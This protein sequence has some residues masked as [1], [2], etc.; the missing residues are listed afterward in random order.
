MFVAAIGSFSSCK[1]YDDDINSVADRVTALESSLKTCQSNCEAQRAALKTE[2]ENKIAALDSKYATLEAVAK[3]QSTA[4]NAKAEAENALAQ[5]VTLSGQISEIEADIE[6]IDKALEEINTVLAGKVDQ[7]DFDAAIESINAKLAAVNT[8]LATLEDGINKNSTAIEAV[9][10]DIAQQKSTLEN[11]GERISTLEEKIKDV[12]V[13]DLKE[14]FTKQIDEVKASI[15]KMQQALEEADAALEKKINANTA[16]IE[17]LK[18]GQQT[19]ANKI[20][21]LCTVTAQIEDDVESL[22]QQV[23]VLNVYVKST[24]RSLVFDPDLYYWGVEGTSL[25]V[26]TYRNYTLTPALNKD[27]WNFKEGYLG[28]GKSANTTKDGGKWGYVD[29]DKESD[30]TGTTGAERD[31]THN[32]FPYTEKTKTMNLVAKYHLN[33]SNA[34]IDEALANWET[35][36]ALNTEDDPFLK[37]TAN[38]APCSLRIASQPYYETVDGV[39]T[40]RLMVPLKV[41]NPDKIKSVANDQAITVFATEI[42]IQ[43]T[44][45]TDADTT[46]TSDYATLVRSDVKDVRIAHTLH[47]A[48]I[49]GTEIYS[50]NPNN[51][52]HNTHCGDCAVNTSEQNKNHNHVMATVHEAHNF[53]ET[54]ING[55]VTF[56]AQDQCL[57]NSRINL[58]DLVETH[59]TDVDGNHIVAGSD[60]MTANGL[61]YVFELTGLWRGDNETSESAHA[62]I[63][64]NEDGTYTFQPQRPDYPTTNV[65]EGRDYCDTDSFTTKNGQKVANQS[66]QQI[67]RTP[68]VRV[69]LVN[70][71]GEVL[72][73]GYIMIQ[74]TSEEE[75]TPAPELTVVEYTGD[76][77]TWTNNGACLPKYDAYGFKTQW[78]QTEY[79]IYSL[80]N[81]N[82]SRERF[83]DVYGNDLYG[84]SPATQF[85]LG[86][87]GNMYECDTEHPAIGKVMHHDDEDAAD[88]QM[89]SILEWSVE[90]DDIKDLI[91]TKGK[92]TDNGDGT[93]TYTYDGVDTWVMYEAKEAGY[94]DIFIHLNTGKLTYK[95]VTPYIADLN[96]DK[97]KIKEYWRE[98]DSAANGSDGG[99][100]ETHVQVLSPDDNLA[101]VCTDFDG[102]FSNLFVNNDLSASTWISSVENG[103]GIKTGELH[104]DL[105]FD[106]K[107][108]NTD[109]RSAGGNT[110]AQFKGI[111]DGKEVTFTMSVS[112]DGKTLFASYNGKKDTVAVIDAYVK[113]EMEANQQKIY[114]HHGEFAEALLNYKAHNEL[115]EDVL[116]AYIIANVY[117]YCY[118]ATG[119]VISTQQIEVKNQKPLVVRFLRPISV[120]SADAKVQDAALTKQI[121]KLA[122]LLQYIDWRDAWNSKSYNPASTATWGLDDGSGKYYK[123]YNITKIEPLDL[124]DGESLSISDATLT[125]LNQATTDT[126]VPLNTVSSE[127]DFIYHA[128]DNTIEYNNLSNTVQSFD[129]KFPVAVYYEWGDHTPIYAWVTIHVE[130][131]EGG[132]AR[133]K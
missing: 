25:T 50:A 72:D 15:T 132:S 108:F 117:R 99:L 9:K 88:G 79:D 107:K 91:T 113:D 95:V 93:V 41:G 36:M 19:L 10:E 112:E 33:P 1:D 14:Q 42:T 56:A 12:N 77:A 22:Q 5:I 92:K 103:D 30:Y 109:D 100:D 81:V 35:R 20:D 8:S 70:A 62:A 115:S 59:Y 21:S 49:E 65:G 78:V 45:G 11:Y 128:E 6:E 124:E 126:W 2:L 98:F 26:L 80:P 106:A 129:V 46:I 61:H 83:K 29:E 82:L 27:S 32:R 130:A 37:S 121:V 69:S 7:E 114:F 57:W 16:D 58:N 118:D 71:D 47:G 76:P 110:G 105:V 38:E 55:G 133:Q 31:D 39:K 86:K 123:Y 13:G 43:A 17:T 87:D 63:R 102:Q 96:W 51:K 40:G 104:L 131:T 54:L 44:D 53:Y 97:N 28:A 64:A 3:A 127:I 60:F 90:F 75:A 84:G 4:D 48:L 122:D 111:L 67:G 52:A 18:K 34:D 94:P 74:I 125:N 89:T 101:D 68:V 85:Y 119:E 116:A 24:L 73:Y 23:N 66:K 120:K